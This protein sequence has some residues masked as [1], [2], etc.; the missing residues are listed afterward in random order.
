MNKTSNTDS[1]NEKLY[2]RQYKAEKN[3]YIQELKQGKKITTDDK[4]KK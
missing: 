3:I 1:K 4:E 2:K